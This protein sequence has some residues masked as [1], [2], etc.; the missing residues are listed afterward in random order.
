MGF[1]SDIARDEGCACTVDADGTYFANG[2]LGA[3]FSGILQRSLFTQQVVGEGHSLGISYCGPPELC[4]LIRSDVANT[5]LPVRVEF[6][7]EGAA[8]A[9][10]C[11]HTVGARRSR[12]RGQRGGTCGGAVIF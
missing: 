9:G 1:G 8:R 12:A 5:V 10:R 6:N 2:S 3:S 4:S 7:A 11:R